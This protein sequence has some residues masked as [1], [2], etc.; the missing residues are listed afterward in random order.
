MTAIAVLVATVL[1]WTAA[2][3]FTYWLDRRS[4]KHRD[5]NQTH[6]PCRMRLYVIS[7][8]GHDD[9]TIEGIFL[10]FEADHYRIASAEHLQTNDAGIPLE[11]EAWVPR[12]RVLYAQAIG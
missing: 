9:A 5:R 3:G 8:H 12:S 4:E 1:G 2:S 7:E 10:G 11:G 6:A